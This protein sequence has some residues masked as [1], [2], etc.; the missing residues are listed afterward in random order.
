MPAEPAERRA[1]WAMYAMSGNPAEESQW[2]TPPSGLYV[3]MSKCLYVYMPICLYVWSATAC[4]KQ[5][6][7]I[8]N[9]VSFLHFL[10]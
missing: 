10:K 8:F 5:K 6:D 2:K 1:P 4:F 9:I 7:P 3:Y